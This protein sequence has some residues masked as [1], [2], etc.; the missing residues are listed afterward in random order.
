VLLHKSSLLRLHQH[1]G[2]DSTS[3]QLERVVLF[4]PVV[5]T[6]IHALCG[7][8]NFVLSS[9]LVA[10]R[11]NNLRL[12]QADEILC[13]ANVVYLLYCLASRDSP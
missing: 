11:E 10:L 3:T 9:L 1:L 2:M 4:S 12:L 6:M 8:R 13:Q 5:L 7:P